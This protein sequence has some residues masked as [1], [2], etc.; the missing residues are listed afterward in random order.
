MK[1]SVIVPVYNVQKYL[2]K[3]IDSILIQTYKNYELI[4]IDDESSDESYKI[5]KEYKKIYSNIKIFTHKNMGPGLTRKEGFQ[6]SK[7][8]LLFFVDSDDTLAN[9][10]VFEK[11]NTIFS[12]NNIDLLM[13]ESRRNPDNGIVNK[14]ISRGCMTEGVHNIEE[15]DNCIIEGCLWM[16]VFKKN[17]FK[18]DFFIDSN[19]FED[20]YTTYKYINECKKF[21]YLEEQLYIVNRL[22]DNNSL[23][24]NMNFDKM[25]KKID[26][27]MK[28]N[29][30]SKLHDSSKLMALDCYMDYTKKL[31]TS[32]ESI[33]NKIK[34]MR[35]LKQLRN[36]VDKDA[37]RLCK[38][39]FKRK[40]IYLYLITKI[41]I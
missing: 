17:K 13:F 24:K 6:K 30:F 20:G 11:I 28:I 8:D 22:D 27:I 31:F 37:I 5:M 23:T 3:L 29:D 16:K 1:I 19:N 4:L 18:E 33:K 39:K 2:S 35:K 26:I 21:Y 12:E 14:V 34:L 9:K 25:L 32:N 41:F 40:A 36:L 10:Y 7:G 38:N 15:L